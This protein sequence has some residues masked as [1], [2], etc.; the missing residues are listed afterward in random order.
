MEGGVTDN[1]IVGGRLAKEG[2]FPFQV[3]VT[4]EKY[5]FSKVAIIMHSRHFL[6]QVSLRRSY[7]HQH[8]CGGSL[9]TSKY[10]LTAAHCMFYRWGGVLPPATIIVVAGQLLLNI[11]E[12]SVLR[13]ASKIVI[14]EAYDKNTMANDVA[15]IEVCYRKRNK[16]I[17]YHISNFK[18]SEILVYYF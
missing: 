2:E 3:S 16:Q 10:V 8:F 11:T 6:L 5:V 14:H 7:N 12:H 4:F 13:S 9:V 18:T 15:L 17:S 1:R